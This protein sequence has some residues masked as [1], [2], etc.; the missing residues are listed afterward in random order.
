M[1]LEY[2]TI[3]YLKDHTNFKC[4]IFILA[5]NE[6]AMSEWFLR[7][8]L[9]M[10]SV[11]CMPNV[12]KSRCLMCSDNPSAAQSQ[13]VNNNRKCQGSSLSVPYER[14]NIHG[15][16]IIARMEADAYPPNWFISCDSPTLVDAEFM[17]FPLVHIING[18]CFMCPWSIVF[19]DR[20]GETKWKT[21]NCQS[22]KNSGCKT[23]STLL[24]TMS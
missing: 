7:A 21:I 15:C 5:G 8:V 13:W 9:V 20:M 16:P 24:D 12:D 22:A 17:G 4:I 14:P 1:I 6:R 19:A 2:S 11:I 10:L 18:Y 3:L 23:T